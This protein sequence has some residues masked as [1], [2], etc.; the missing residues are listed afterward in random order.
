[1]LFNYLNKKYIETYNLIVKNI[2]LYNEKINGYIIL[3]RIIDILYT[4]FYTNKKYVSIFMLITSKI[5]FLLKLEL[6]DKEEF[7][8]LCNNIIDL[9]NKNFDIIDCINYL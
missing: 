4:T 5:K 1:M 8:N 6:N 2:Y 3:I 9:F 7:I